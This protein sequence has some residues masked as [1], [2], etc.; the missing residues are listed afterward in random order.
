[1]V[2][3]RWSKWSKVRQNTA[4]DLLFALFVSELEAAIRWRHKSVFVIRCKSA[5]LPSTIHNANYYP[6][7]CLFSC[8]GS[9]RWR[10]AGNGLAAF[11]LVLGSFGSCG[12]RSPARCS[13]RV[14]IPFLLRFGGVGWRF[15]FPFSGWRVRLCI[16]ESL[17]LSA[18]NFFIFRLF[19]EFLHLQ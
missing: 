7:V 19:L 13:F 9:I 18:Q 16:Y 14:R 2:R 5:C 4:L 15:P 3:I 10:G 11:W 12:W 6:M 17:T 1:M 8:I